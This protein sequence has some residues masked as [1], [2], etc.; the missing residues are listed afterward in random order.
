MWKSLSGNMQP[1]KLG[2]KAGKRLAA[3]TGQNRD[4][5][6]IPHGV[7]TLLYDTSSRDRLFPSCGRTGKRRQATAYGKCLVEYD[8]LPICSLPEGG[9][10]KTYFILTL[11]EA[12]LRTNAVLFVFSSKDPR[13]PCRFCPSGY[14]TRCTSKKEDMLHLHLGRFL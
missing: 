4:F 13:G 10:G 7:Y 11:I 2:E 3:V 1:F 8:K 5:K 12:L 9:G 6:R 14:V